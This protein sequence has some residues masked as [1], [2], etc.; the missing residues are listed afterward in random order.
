MSRPPGATV[1][2]QAVLEG[3]MMRA[4]NGWA[5]AVRRPDGVIEAMSRELPRLSSRSRLAKIPFFRG[6]M[7]L[8][9][10]LSLGF[11]ALSWSAQKAGIEEEGDEEIPKWQIALTMVVA[12]VLGIALFA[13]IP[14]FAA[15]FLKRYLGD[16]SIAFVVLDGVIRIALIVGYMWVISRSKEIQRVFEYHGAEHMTIH[17]YEAGD[18]MSVAAVERYSPRHPRCGTS[19]LILVGLVAFFVF[20]ALAELPFTWQV[21]SRILLIPVIAGISYEVLKAAAGYRWMAWASRPG[22]WLQA[23]T[24]KQPTDD[25][26]EVAIAS[27]LAALDDEERSSVESRGAIAPGALAVEFDLEAD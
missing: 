5:V 7:V 17:A 8:V 6:I 3:V 10:S 21:A 20:L 26:I 22:M 11:R 4:P 27:L 15:D 25:Q 24:T 19:F 13:L 2:G 18:P 9:E 12:I 23:I 16:S 1:G 14:V